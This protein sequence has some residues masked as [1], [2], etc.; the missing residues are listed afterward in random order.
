MYKFHI[1]HLLQLLEN[2]I[3]KI[4]NMSVDKTVL[5]IQSTVVFGYVGNKSGAFPLQVLF[6]LFNCMN[7]MHYSAIHLLMS[8]YCL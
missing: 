3:G 8:I 4:C 5:S 2:A 7:Y 1:L 6:Y